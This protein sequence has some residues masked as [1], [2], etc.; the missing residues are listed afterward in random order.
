MARWAR[1][2]D[3]SSSQVRGDKVRPWSTDVTTDAEIP[4]LA[5]RDN[6]SQNHNNDNL[7]QKHKNAPEQ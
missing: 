2:H 1:M 7:S 5:R 4:M 6:L 3:S